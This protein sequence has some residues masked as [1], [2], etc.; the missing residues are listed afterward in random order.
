M[1]ARDG[2]DCKSCGGGVAPSPLRPHF[3]PAGSTAVVSHRSRHSGDLSSQLYHLPAAWRDSNL[4]R[5]REGSDGPRP[6]LSR[7]SPAFNGQPKSILVPARARKLLHATPTGPSVAANGFVHWHVVHFGSVWE[8][9]LHAM[10]LQ[11]SGAELGH[12]RTASQRN[13]GTAIILHFKLGSI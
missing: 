10:H 9:T 13:G 8:L 3:S 5:S 2:E 11:S 1:A 6:I 12:V 7:S 4:P